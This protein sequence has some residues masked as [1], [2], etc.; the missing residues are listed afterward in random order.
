MSF[1]LHIM[2]RCRHRKKQMW[3]WKCKFHY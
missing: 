2:W 1:F 3:N